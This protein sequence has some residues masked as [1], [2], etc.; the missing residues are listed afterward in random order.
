M[1]KDGRASSSNHQVVSV[2]EHYESYGQSDNNDGIDEGFNGYVRKPYAN[3]KLY[4]G[5]PTSTWKRMCQSTPT[6][7]KLLNR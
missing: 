1:G 2:N 7:M 6:S 5:T 4:R 3:S